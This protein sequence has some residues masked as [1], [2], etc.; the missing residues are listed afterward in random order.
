MSIYG[1]SACYVDLLTDVM[2]VATG[3]VV[4]PFFGSDENRTGVWRSPKIITRD[5]PSF[6]WAK[7][8]GTLDAPVTLRIYANGALKYTTPPI[9]NREAVR[10][11]AGRHEVWEIEVESAGDINSVAI[12]STA[13]ELA[14]A[15]P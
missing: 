10:L 15:K 11:P 9:T 14:D 13:Q 8:N 7:V 3:N 1:H 5:Y 4:R 12:A 2:Y 6:A